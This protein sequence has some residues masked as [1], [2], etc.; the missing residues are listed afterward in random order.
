MSSKNEYIMRQKVAVSVVTFSKSEDLVNELEKDFDVNI[1][2]T[3]R[4]YTK[5]ELID[6]LREAD[7]AI[8]GLDNV[9]ESVLRY[10]P[11]LRVISKYGIGVDQIDFED[12]KKY[13]VEIIR[14][15]LG[16]NSRS[17]SELTLGYML[18]LMRGAYTTSSEMKEGS[19]N[20]Y[21]NKGRELT[22]KTVGIIGVG[23][24]GKNLV[25]LL[26]P[27]RLSDF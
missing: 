14:K 5:E 15:G 25:P 27:I 21:G 24:I 13:G 18:G 16:L 6:A 12:C 2:T 9:D 20:K 7:A 8:T 1:N 19:W 10:C 11:N 3:G 17:V 26:K 22:R 23:N 4:R